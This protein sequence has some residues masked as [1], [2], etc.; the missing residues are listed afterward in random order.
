M[1]Y[2]IIAE[3]QGQRLMGTHFTADTVYE[4]LARVQRIRSRG[5]LV[6]LSGPDGKPVSENDLEADAA[7]IRLL[8][9]RPGVPA[10]P[11]LGRCRS[12]A[13]LDR[14]T[15]GG[16]PLQAESGGRGSLA[17]ARGRRGNAPR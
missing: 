2:T 17:R 6:K 4:A 16:H 3:S 5:F 12:A 9:L 1:A 14:L 13:T 10:G 11:T 7:G 8:R 15:E